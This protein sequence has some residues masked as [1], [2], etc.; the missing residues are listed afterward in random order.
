MVEKQLNYRL[1]LSLLGGLLVFCTVVHFVHGYQVDRHAG[2]LRTQAEQAEKAGQTDKAIKLLERYLTFTPGDTESL[3]HCGRLLDKQAHSPSARWRVVTVFEQV[4]D[5]QPERADLRRRVVE[6]QMG[7]EAYK[8]ANRHLDI[9]IAATPNDGE[10][11][12][13]L[14]Q[15]KEGQGEND[16]A[17]ANYEKAIAHAPQRV[18]AHAHLAGLLRRLDKP[19]RADDVMDTLVRTNP[20]S[21][22]AHLERGLYRLGNG[23]IEPAGL[24][25]EQA[26]A[27]APDDPRVLVA[28]AELFHR[29][30]KDDDA[31][32][33]WERGREKYPNNLTMVLGLAT[34]DLQ[35][36]R[37]PDAVACLNQGLQLAGDEPDLLHLL[38]EAYLQQHDTDKARA[39][40][41]RLK[42]QAEPDLYEYLTGRILQSGGQ[43]DGAIHKFDRV[44]RNPD[45]SNALRS[46]AWL[47]LGECYQRLGDTDR[48]VSA[49]KNAVTLE[50]SLVPA[51]NGLG[52]AYLALG[53]IED[54]L[55][56]YRQLA[57][58][59]H[60]PSEV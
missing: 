31:R 58:L 42:Q 36:G 53:R 44:A 48:Q 38:T 9:L 21:A 20:Q 27:L 30:G 35:T 1:V 10:L 17:V 45:A 5:R 23:L 11:E 47:A 43:W 37:T 28:S 14:G 40:V 24:D 18:A 33:S 55:E 46:R 51:R 29:L 26:R 6:L 39:T 13:L 59:P 12:N 16:Q 32:K 2:S 3:E 49:Y 57:Q 34:L 15:C 41:A 19:G 54:A 7:L 4:L 60:P 8:E 22:D 56:Q 50:P 52:S 25:L